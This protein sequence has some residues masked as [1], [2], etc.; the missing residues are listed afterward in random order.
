M[1]AR[2]QLEQ[3][4]A[5]LGN[6][7]EDLSFGIKSPQDGLKLY[8]Y[9]NAHPELPEFCDE[10]ADEE[11]VDV[12]E[13]RF[14][15]LGYDPLGV[16]EGPASK[17]AHATVRA[18]ALLDELHPMVE[19]RVSSLLKSCPLQ[20]TDDDVGLCVKALVH[21][22]LVEVGSHV[23]PLSNEGRAIVKDLKQK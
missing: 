4:A 23:Q 12:A 8:A 3:A 20:G 6:Q 1:N 21:V 13:H 15:A 11:N 19:A 22:A 17:E 10:G 14:M 9:W 18:K 7:N 16:S 2:E 5:W